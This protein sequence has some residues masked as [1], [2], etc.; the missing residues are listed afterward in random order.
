MKNKN[1]DDYFEKK[2]ST[3]MDIGKVVG[4]TLA[5]VASGTIYW[6]Y[7][8]ELGNIANNFF[9]ITGKYAR[10]AIDSYLMIPIAAPLFVGFMYAGDI[11]GGTIA[12]SFLR[13]KEGFK[14]FLIKKSYEEN[15]K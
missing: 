15:K 11:I 8:E 5:T 9:G 7:G 12:G 1:L 2:I 10:G 3:G 14:N 13:K 4:A 6:Y